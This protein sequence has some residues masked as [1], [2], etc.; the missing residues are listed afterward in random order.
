[1]Y[2]WSIIELLGGASVAFGITNE[3]GELFGG[4]FGNFRFNVEEWQGCV[5]VIAALGN[6]SE[7]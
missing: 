7:E 5:L 4:G 2:V 1:L 3:I 6:K